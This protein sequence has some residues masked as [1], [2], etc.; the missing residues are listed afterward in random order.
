LALVASIS[1]ILLVMK[2]TLPTILDACSKFINSIAP[3]IIELISTIYDG[4][5]KLILALGTTLPP[6]IDSVGG[7]F[8]KVFGGMEGVIRAIGDTISNIL[9]T[10]KSLV[11]E[12]LKAI[13][14]FIEK[15]APAINKFVDGVCNAVTKLIN[16]VISGIEYMINTL[17]I[18]SINK[19]I[20][21]MTSGALGEALE[22]LGVEIKT[23]AKVKIE[24]FKPTYYENGGFPSEGELFIAREK[25]AELV[26]NMN[27]KTAVANN[28]QIVKGI[29]EASFQGMMRALSASGGRNTKVEITAEGDTSGLLDFITFSQKKKNRRNEL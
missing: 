18:G 17:I 12:V 16:F 24:R 22:L 10:A 8:E 19:L 13:L 9:R 28:D 14:N 4:I 27:G 5:E 11:T 2:E 7:V 29:E 1:A 23:V 6:I 26:G 25:G 21:T 3:F 15:L 20:K